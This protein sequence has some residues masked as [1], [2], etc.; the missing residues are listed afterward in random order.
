MVGDSI[1]DLCNGWWIR[2]ERPHKKMLGENKLRKLVV[3]ISPCGGD[4][5]R[6]ECIFNRDI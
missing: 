5:G 2:D 1:L 4:K 6:Y 3:E